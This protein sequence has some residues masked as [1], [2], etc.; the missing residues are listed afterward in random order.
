MK[1]VEVKNWDEF[2]N[3]A[4]EL[5]DTNKVVLIIISK[6]IFEKN[7]LDLIEGFRKD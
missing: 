4:D 7:K 5:Y 1:T 3:Y 2:L 6:E